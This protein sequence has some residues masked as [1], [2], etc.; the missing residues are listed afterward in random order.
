MVVL[1]CCASLQ[2]IA[3]HPLSLTS[4]QLR[5]ISISDT[6]QLTNMNLTNYLVQHTSNY[7]L[8]LHRKLRVGVF[9]YDNVHTLLMGNTVNS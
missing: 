9:M 6:T 1:N 4:P 3:L 2:F 8:T 7:S 5:Q